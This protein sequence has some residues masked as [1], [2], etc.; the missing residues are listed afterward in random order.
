VSSQ[1][2]IFRLAGPVIVM[3]LVSLLCCT[4]FPHR[5]LLYQMVLLQL[6]DAL[7]SVKEP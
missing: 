4:L 1:A 5:H 6:A 7:I 3:E 2:L